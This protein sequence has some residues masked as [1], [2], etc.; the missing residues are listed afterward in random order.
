MPIG[1]SGDARP[2]VEELSGSTQLHY[3]DVSAEWMKSRTDLT[4]LARLRW[5]N[6][7]PVKELA[8]RFG[9]T[10][11]TINRNISNL[12]DRNWQGL[13]LSK[14]EFAVIK[15]AAAKEL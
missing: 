15:K 6:K 12:K 5:I 9:K 3:I 14:S 7:L 4:E 1:G 11:E 13:K 10:T 8:K 2:I